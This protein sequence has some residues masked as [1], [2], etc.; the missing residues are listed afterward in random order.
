MEPV[1][2]M[3]S[4]DLPSS[5]R[6]IGP[7]ATSGGDPNAE[8]TVPVEVGSA[9]ESR[10]L[11]PGEA[12]TIRG[13]PAPPSS[14][15]TTTVAG[16]GLTPPS[17]RSPFAP[18]ATGSEL[19]FAPPLPTAPPPPPAQGATFGQRP[20]G[21][22]GAPTAPYPLTSSPPTSSSLTSS[23]SDRDLWQVSKPMLPASPPTFDGQ[24]PIY[25]G[26]FDAD[27]RVGVHESSS[28][29]SGIH[30]VRLAVIV[31]LASALI[32]ALV[33]G[34]MFL[35][36]DRGE[37]A[38]RDIAP[39]S[40]TRLAPGEP[41]DIQSL[42]TK[43]QPSVVAIQTGT[44]VMEQL[45]GGA[46][47]GVVI[48][49]DGLALTNA[50]VIQGFS[51]MSV[52]LFDG[53]VHEASLVGSSPD[54]DIALI[55][56]HDVSGLKPA[57]LGSSA[58]ALVGDDVVAI[59]NALNLGGPPSVTEG[60]ISAKDRTI[61]APGVTLQGLIQ[62]DAAI[63]PG[64]SGGPLINAYGEVIGI[65]TAII[66]QA[67][68]VGFAIGID[69]IKPLIEELRAGNGDIT[70]DTAFMGVVTTPVTAVSS[71]DLERYGVT[72]DEGAF[73]A[74]VMKNSSASDAGLQVGDVITSVNGQPITTSSDVAAI[75]QSHDAGDRITIVYE[76]SG[77]ESEVTVELR[78]RRDS[79]D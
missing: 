46:G 28:T 52:T 13:F 35:L 29:G 8:A 71:A 2:D 66:S 33:T 17:A 34:S 65:N 5:D 6:I 3:N 50:H 70:L 16:G 79:G 15:P 23:S 63:N 62:T 43:A 26:Q 38:S 11:P 64:N 9:P 51:Q 39:V 22:F 21:S 67:Q 20:A 56:I 49:E 73:V 53:T 40:N 47:T 27:G 37:V 1:V 32:A 60:I 59:G 58:D 76:R 25:H 69:L 68:N 7:Q 41:L 44:T 4:G 78:S 72:V 42:L 55:Q 77:K 74:D 19:H 61:E 48:S 45:Y 57:E 24:R 30:G 54:D 36:F 12:T 14:V 10:W 75:V 18:P 31:G